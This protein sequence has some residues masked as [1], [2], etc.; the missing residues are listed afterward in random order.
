MCWKKSR[1]LI[2]IWDWIRI[3]ETV[4]M[5]NLYSNVEPENTLK[6]FWQNVDV[7]PSILGKQIRSS[8]YFYRYWIFIKYEKVILMMIIFKDPICSALDLKC[9]N[10]VTVN[11]SSC[12]KPC[13]GLIVTSFSKS[14]QNTNLADMSLIL[15]DYDTF[16]KPTA[17]PSGLNGIQY[18]KVYIMNHL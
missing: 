8:K 2:H 9:I 12:L 10:N 1:W 3:S 15:K 13:S 5:K 14:A 16:K 7:C 17:F 6:R 11:T 18:Y 4:K